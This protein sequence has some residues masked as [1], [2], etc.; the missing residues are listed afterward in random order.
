MLKILLFLLSLSSFADCSFEFKFDI[1]N[2]FDSIR[3]KSNILQFISEKGYQ[4]APSQNTVAIK[5]YLDSDNGIY[6]PKASTKVYIDGVLKYYAY[7]EGH[8]FARL[9]PAVR[10]KNVFKSAHKSISQI[11][12]CL[13]D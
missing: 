12:S 3:L 13:N 11:P 5:V 8:S 9:K 2:S 1:D 7:G 6:R 10:F 4:D